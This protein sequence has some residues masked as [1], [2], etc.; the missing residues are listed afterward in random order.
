MLIP[1]VPTI[2]FYAEVVSYNVWKSHHSIIYKSEILE[3]S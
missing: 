3:A 1:L 2:H